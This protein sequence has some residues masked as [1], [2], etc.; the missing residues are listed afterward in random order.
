MSQPPPPPALA[1]TVRVAAPVSDSLQVQVKAT[2][3]KGSQVGFQLPSWTP[4]WYVLR[5][6]EA[7][8]SGFSAKGPS[9][10]PLTIQQTES[11]TWQVELA[12]ATEVTFSYRIRASDTGLGF[13][14]P[15]LDERHG[16][17]PGPATLV[18][19]VGQKEAP[20]SVAYEVPEGWEVASAN[21][22]V[23]GK[24]HTFT[25]PNYDTLIDQPAELGHFSRH[26][27]LIQGVPVSVVLVGTEGIDTTRWVSQVFRIA[28][29]GIRVL[30]GAPFPRYTF[31]F[32]VSRKDGF[33]GGLEH[34]NGTVIRIAPSAIRQA[35]AEDLAL[36]AHEFVHAW[37][38]KRARPA[39]L[40]PFDYTKPVRVKDLWFC[41]GVTDYYAPRLLVEAGIATQRFW[42]GYHAEQLSTLME[43]PARH[44]ITLEDAS[45]KVWESEAE[46]Q[47]A[48]GLSYYNKG[49][50][51]G[52]LLDIELRRRTEN[53]VGLD[54]LV[55][56][57]VAQAQKTGRGFAEG[58]IE[59]LASSLSG[60]D[61][62]P[63]FTRALRSTQELAIRTTL[64]SG[65]IFAEESVTRTPTL[66][67][68]WDLAASGRGQLRVK[69]VLE[70]GPA[71]QAG[72]RA[73]D[74]VVGMGGVGA[75]AF[76]GG[77]LSQRQPGEPLA[78]AVRRDNRVEN[79]VL[80][81]GTETSIRYRL[82]P[83]SRPTALQAG[84][85]ASI[86]GAR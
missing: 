45:W 30:G 18:Y 75:D 58:E 55:K 61:F 71:A 10:K 19:L 32:H 17:V 66:G 35:E 84:I 2:G 36:V 70:K 3:L 15:Y 26:E 20:C 59:R 9:G 56:A 48:G 49:L 78:V 46:S 69:Q 51:V 57:L 86:S 28:E 47:G 31:F 64:E 27:R 1:Y 29:A 76:L 72:L 21:T 34:L 33:W 82:R 24:P 12:G 80:T 14:E 25:A 8:F 13:F 44:G 63:F 53:K 81:L 43:N 37:N 79:I 5:S 74:V 50:V 41:E 65:G 60:T 16:F 73:G 38:V 67:L 22:P 11:R 39:A 40:G 6:N 85:L 83:L 54:D 62:A 77:I 68:E 42:L 52:L 23:P 4:G 7:N